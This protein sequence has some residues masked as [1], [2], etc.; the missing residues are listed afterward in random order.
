MSKE[1]MYNVRIRFKERLDPTEFRFK[2]THD[3][4]EWVIVTP[5]RNRE[6]IM[7][8]GR[9]IVPD[10]IWSLNIKRINAPPSNPSLLQR[11]T[12]KWWYYDSS[13]AF[14]GEGVDVTDEFI[15]GSPGSRLAESGEDVSQ[16][17]SRADTRKVFV[18]HGRN[19]AARDALFA[20]LRAIGLH[21][22]EWSEAVQATGKPLPYIG[23]ILDVAFSEA[24][25]V[26]VLLTPDDEARLQEHLWDDDEPPQETELIGQARPNVLFEAGMAMGRWGDRTVFVEFG[27]LR[28]FSDVAGR[29]TIRIDGTSKRRQ[30]LAKRLEAAGCPVNLEGTDWHTA[31]DFDAALAESTESSSE[32]DPTFEQLQ[33]PVALPHLS[34]EAKT[35]LLEAAIS[36]GGEIVRIRLMG[37]ASIGT[38]GKEYVEKGNPRLEALWTSALYELINF[39]F[40]NDETGKGQVFRVTGEGYKVADA[41]EGK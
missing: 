21:P 6:H 36:K 37:G 20:F 5:Y 3:Y 22:L 4:L 17:D 18:V 32:P 13:S 40:V 27:T 12:S 23:E 10:D 19:M 26:V 15:A 16:P 14:E 28:P 1:Y 39:G 33:T 38:N 31:G 41:F 29:H 25:A 9:I 7:L 35:L 24:H 34:K 30:E 11:L 8:D 2:L